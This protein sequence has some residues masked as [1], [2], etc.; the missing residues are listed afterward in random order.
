MSFTCGQIRSQPYGLTTDFTCSYVVSSVPSAQQSLEYLTFVDQKLGPLILSP[1]IRYFLDKDLW[2]LLGAYRDLE[3]HDIATDIQSN[4]PTGDGGPAIKITAY[5]LT[6]TA[7]T[8]TFGL[9][10]FLLTGEGKALQ[11]NV[12]DLVMGVPLAL[13]YVRLFTSC[14]C[15]KSLVSC[16]YI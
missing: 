7:T 11:A 6:V 8:I 16:F 13:L 9:A 4:D 12:I 1:Q 15:S 2:E 10:K 5:R 3:H 14:M